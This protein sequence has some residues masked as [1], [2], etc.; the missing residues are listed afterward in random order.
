M[1]NIRIMTI[2]DYEGII[3]LWKEEGKVP[4]NSTDD[5]LEG[6]TRY[7]KRNPKTSFVAENGGKIVG[8][9]MS[10]HDG[11]RG[12][13]H[14]VYVS[15]KYRKQGIG[16]KLVESAMNALKEEGIS[17]TALVVFSDNEQGNGFWKH[18]GF[19]TRNDLVYRNKLIR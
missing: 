10:G 7:L 13:F 12:F 9:I 4:L 2:N 14:H 1:T 18:I 17:K 15:L 19:T 8:T 11:R 5:S 6:I 3:G 16:V